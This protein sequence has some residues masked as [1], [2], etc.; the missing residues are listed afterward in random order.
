[1]RHK[2]WVFD[3]LGLIFIRADLEEVAAKAEAGYPEEVC[4]L[5]LGPAQGPGIDH[6]VWIANVHPDPGRAFTLHEQEH[7][8]ALMRADALNLAV[9]VLCHSHI[10]GPPTLSWRDRAGAVRHG[11]EVMPA[12]LHLIVSVHEGRRGSWAVHRYDPR[13]AEFVTRD[14]DGLW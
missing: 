14:G 12:V 2:G 1:M 7:L 11:I 4:G 6:W 8:R 10:D 13:R 3:A 9:K 5:A